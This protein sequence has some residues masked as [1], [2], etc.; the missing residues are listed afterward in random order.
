SL[1]GEP[2]GNEAVLMDKCRDEN[3]TLHDI[4]PLDPT[5]SD[6]DD[7]SFRNTPKLV[8]VSIAAE[9][10]LLKTSEATNSHLRKVIDKVHGRMHP[11]GT[12]ALVVP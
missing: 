2:S 3:A 10:R 11:D 4:V 12:I 6:L 9:Q 5:G 1:L 8:I 7:L